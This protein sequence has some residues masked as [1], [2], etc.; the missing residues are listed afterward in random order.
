MSLRRR[1]SRWVALLRYHRPSQFGWRLY[2][3]IQRQLRKRLPQ[4]YVFS[5]SHGRVRWKPGARVAMAK[6]AQRRLRLW[7]LRSVHA[8]AMADGKFCYL[9]ETRD[10][11]IDSSASAI[12]INW[13]PDAPRLWRF[14]LQCHED[15]LEIVEAKGAAAAFQIVDS[16]IRDPRHRSPSGD[17]DAWHPFCISRRMPVWLALAAS[18]DLPVGLQEVFWKSV[19]DQLAWLCKNCEW[20]LGGNHLLENLTAIYL[21]DC[22]LDFGDQET[23]WSVETELMRQL[24]DQILPSGEHYERAPTYHALMLVC[25]LQC[26]EAAKYAASPSCEAMVKVAGRMTQLARWLRQPDGNMPLLSDSAREETP[27]LDL[28]FAWADDHVNEADFAGETGFDGAPDYWMHQSEPGDRLIF[29][30]GPLACDH[31]PAHG[32]AD[33]LQ[34]TATISGRD[35]IV[36]TGNYQYEP[37]DMRTYCRRT[38]AHNVLQLDEREQCDV[39]SSFR[40]GRRGHPTSIHRGQIAGYRWCSAMHDG[41]S[42]PTGR[43]VLGGDAC[44]TIIDW[45][46]GDRGRPL[47]TSRLHW[48][49]DWQLEVTDSEESATAWLTD[50][51][52]KRCRITRLNLTGK[53]GLHDGYYCPCFGEKV[54]NQVLVNQD[55][56]TGKGWLGL[57]ISLDTTG[58]STPPVVT[59]KDTNILS[60]LVTGGGSIALSMQDGSVVGPA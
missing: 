19:S 51:P 16:W 53:L 27:D 10:L 18:H 34:I 38:S 57:F 12:Q 6:I 41:F 1:I 22:F 56:F 48:H 3:I 47:A 14:H 11:N 29:D 37:G 54:A 60:I 45:F 39:W 46:V 21:A 58:V 49:P 32:H 31:L 4:R 35:A 30:V 15:M 33:L 40:M 20:D 17:P 5:P 44:W 50:N 2:R 24:A 43:I 8:A 59:L 26:I 36:D 28:L 23:R 42:C 9:N 7:P 25:T 13:N 52:E 55:R